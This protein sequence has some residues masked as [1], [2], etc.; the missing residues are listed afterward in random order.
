MTV[1]LIIATS[2]D[3]GIGLDN[4]LPWYCPEDLQYF[5]N[6]TEG[7]TV[8]MGNTTYKDLPFEN[9]L[10]RRINYVLTKDIPT[11]DKLGNRRISTHA[12]YCNYLWLTSQLLHSF[13][14][15]WVIGGATV[16][17]EMLPVVEEIHHTL[18]KGEYECDTF[19]DMSFLH[20]GEWQLVSSKELSDMAVVNVWKRKEKLCGN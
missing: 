7:S 9:G 11:L 20:N 1:K 2:V 10:P 16:Y 12:L 6:N 3:Y 19:F 15:S 13:G 8:I 4:K 14:N 17:K 18:M 5:K